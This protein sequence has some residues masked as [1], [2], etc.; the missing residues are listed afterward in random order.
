M[1]KQKKSNKTIKSNKKQQSKAST[2]SKKIVDDFLGKFIKIAPGE[3]FM[4]TENGHL[5]EKPVHKVIISKA[6]EI[7]ATEVTQAQWQMIMDNNPSS[8]KGAKLPVENVSWEETQQFIELINMLSPSYNYR[9]PTEA[10]WE[11]AAKAGSNDDYAGDLEKLAWYEANSGGKTHPV[12]RKQPNAWGLYDVHG[13]VQ[14]WCQD[15]Y[16]TYSSE[17]VT[18][19]PGPESGSE[20]VIK[21]GGWHSLAASCRCASRVIGLPINHYFYVGFRLVRTP[22]ESN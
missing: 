4:G 22:K 15:W 2:T 1:N 11:Y 9:L 10:E 20:K 8:F 7:C 13:N 3:F 12:G 6:F 18:D 21:G 16:D 19:P 17:T 5:D 14:E